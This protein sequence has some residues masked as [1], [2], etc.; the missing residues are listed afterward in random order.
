MDAG[1]RRGGGDKKVSQLLVSE[2][3][4]T[5]SG[6]SGRGAGPKANLIWVESRTY[7]L[8]IRLKRKVNGNG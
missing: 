6:K 2:N 1:S 7:K 8:M 3:G 4:I 5:M